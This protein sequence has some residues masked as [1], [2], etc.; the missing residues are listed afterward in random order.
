MKAAI[1]QLE[2]EASRKGRTPTQDERE[3][4]VKKAIEDWQK[5][6]G[7]QFQLEILYYVLI[8]CT[9]KVEKNI[10][11][12]MDDTIEFARFL[13]TTRKYIICPWN[14]LTDAGYDRH[15][16]AKA[17]L[18]DSYHQMDVA[19][20][21]LRSRKQEGTVKPIVV[22]IFFA[23]YNEK[24][25][26]LPRTETNIHGEDALRV[27]IEQLENLFKN[28]KDVL[29]WRLVVSDNRSDDGTL[30][31]A[32]S[33]LQDCCTRSKDKVILYQV[34]HFAPPMKKGGT[35][36]FVM[37]HVL[38]KY[39]PK[40]EDLFGYTDADT[41]VRLDLLGLLIGPLVENSMTVA[42]GSR[43]IEGAV[44]VPGVNPNDPERIV[45]N[46]MV[47]VREVIRTLLLGGKL[48]DTGIE[49]F[50]EVEDTQCGF[51]LFP[52]KVIK[53][54][55]LQH[56]QD[57]G[58]AFDTEWLAL[59]LFARYKLKEIPVYWADS[60]VLSH[61]APEMRKEMIEDWLC[62]FL[63]LYVE[64]KVAHKFDYEFL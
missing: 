23:T 61:T 55:I 48:G 43:T 29:D 27:K 32:E 15:E 47:P 35:L 31:V 22:W 38:D 28:Y 58:W 26:L 42:V 62:Q 40:E 37:Q 30:E 12:P 18:D 63:R 59:A 19:A 24:A 34:P 9:A 41:T 56:A 45:A 57:Y 6:L 46:R 2:K 36:L 4:K 60:R 3:R 10:K 7:E 13:K 11:S 17:L 20:K 51:K 54:V 44:S 21:I 52:L 53:D 25:R 5:I 14:M 64:R 16:D 8:S 49:I 50:R 33:I 1:E 39:S